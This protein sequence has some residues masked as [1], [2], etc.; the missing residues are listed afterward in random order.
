MVRIQTIA[1]KYRRLIILFAILIPII[2]V[3]FIYRSALL[4]SLGKSHGLVSTVEYKLADYVPKDYQLI[5]STIVIS[6]NKKTENSEG[7]PSIDIVFPIVAKDAG[8]L[9]W[10]LNSLE[11]FFPHYNEIILLV[12]KQDLFV[13]RGSIPVNQGRYKI[14]VVNNPF[15]EAERI[16]NKHF[17]YI[18]QQVCVKVLI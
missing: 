14:A 12:E 3:L 17:G 15:V 13:V 6:N 9:I 8:L 4:H 2:C 7:W 11:I 18:I 16:H 10:L 1:Q 5:S